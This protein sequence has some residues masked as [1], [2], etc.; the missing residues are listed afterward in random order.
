MDVQHALA[1][2]LQLA[3]SGRTAPA[4]DLLNAI[5]ARH[6]AEPDAL[7]LLGMIA[8]AGK[9][10]ETAAALFRRSLAARP[11]QPH[12]L[13]NLGNALLDMGQPE[14]AV[15]AYREALEIEPAYVDALTNC[16]LA[17]LA[18][19]DP[20]AARDVLERTLSLDR[21]NAKAWSALG[22]ALKATDQFADAIAA[23]GQSLVLRPDH[24][25]TLHNLAVALRLS[26]EA[27]PAASIL[28]QCAAAN[29]RSAEIRYNLGHCHYDLGRLD[30]AAG[31]YRA[32]VELDPGYA[33]AHDSLNR[34]LWQQGD[35]SNYLASYVSAL[36]QQSENAELT[37]ALAHRLNLEGRTDASVALLDD[38]IARG[39]DTAP[40]RSRLGRA[41]WEEGDF[42]TSMLHHRRAIEIEPKG[43]EQR[44]ELV[45]ALIILERY[46]EAQDAL[47]PVFALAPFDQLAIAYQGLIW[48][49]TGDARADRINDYDR[50][51]ARIPLAPAPEAGGTEAF[52]H[53][54][55][56]ALARL[57]NTNEHP[58]E[59]TLRGGTQTM[60]DLFGRNEP[61]IDAV[62]MMIERAVENYIVL[63]PDDPDHPFLKRKGAG[64]RFSGSWSVRLRRQGFHLDHV[65]SEGWISS[66]YYVGLPSAVQD[67]VGRQGWIKFGETG[68]LPGGRDQ[69]AL[70]IRPEVGTLILFPS[71]MFHGTVPFEGEEYRTTIAFDVVPI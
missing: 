58:L 71:Y 29:P 12:V 15:R 21:N 23:F 14:E 3:Q 26:G 69:A 17:L 41:R 38:A 57:H 37:A 43:I 64:F 63:L 53:R 40:I 25:P 30:Q 65:H 32:A 49:F 42:E 61:E 8:R 28:R 19:D 34:L 22:R 60:G 4:T 13:N 55:E 51:V 27:E 1:Q 18:A 56:N 5:L 10:N 46:A 9:D 6:P 2:A 7:Q 54:L 35:R 62:Q 68:F 33:D 50:L 48:R 20:A 52:N 66:C 16:G 70:S 31:E 11:R 67:V 47:A 45:R 24:V 44:L 59:Q 39:I 36:Q